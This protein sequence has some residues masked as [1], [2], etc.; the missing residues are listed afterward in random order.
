MPTNLSRLFV[1]IALAILA[2]ALMA[3]E[4]EKPV[5]LHEHPTLVAMCKQNNAWRAAVK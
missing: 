2:P 4:P 3:E 5:P 1:H